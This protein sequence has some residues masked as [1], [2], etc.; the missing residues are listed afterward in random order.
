MDAKPFKTLKEQCDY[1]NE[2]KCIFTDFEKHKNYLIKVGYFNI[3]NAYKMPFVD[4]IQTKSDGT[5]KHYYMNN[6]TFDHFLNIYE[7]DNSLRR[8]L[9]S[10]LTS[11]EQEIKNLYAYIIGLRNVN[12][13]EW[14]SL[15]LYNLS[16]SEDEINKVIGNI[17]KKVNSSNNYKYLDHYK[18]KYGELPIWIVL[19]N[20]MLSDFIDF[21]KIMN[22]DVNMILCQIYD[23]TFVEDDRL[24]MD[25]KNLINYLNLIR[26][27][28]NACAHNERTYHLMK[29]NGM[30]SLRSNI[31]FNRFV[32]NP[33]RYTRNGYNYVSLI[34]LL[35]C[36]KYFL[37]HKDYNKLIIEIIDELNKL[38]SLIPSSP[39]EKVLSNIGAKSIE[40]LC[41][42]ANNNP[43]VPNYAI[44]YK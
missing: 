7:F 35:V 36:L 16:K 34:D 37:S 40:D 8:K 22:P 12:N 11:L 44:L 38:K 6:I 18:N 41:F 23:F 30:G 15:D 5:N 39:F 26:E 20:I 2:D 27:Y 31:G 32:I 33:K 3:I 1:L 14:K 25:F 21:I 13:K 19:K 28:R 29:T 10:T 17:E 4:R 43:T 9:F 42:L 24:K